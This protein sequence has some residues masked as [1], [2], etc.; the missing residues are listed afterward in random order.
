MKNEQCKINYTTYFTKFTDGLRVQKITASVLCGQK[1]VGQ[2]HCNLSI[3]SLA[4]C[5]VSLAVHLLI[6][7]VLSQQ[8]IV[9]STRPKSATCAQTLHRSL[10]GYHYG[11]K[12][13][14]R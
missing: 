12:G 6:T 14:L 2:C 13:R 10:A 1:G 11:E 9:T 5:P 4:L 8:G 7:D 3:V